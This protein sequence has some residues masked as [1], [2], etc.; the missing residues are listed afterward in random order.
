MNK[1]AVRN[2]VLLLII[3]LLISIIFSIYNISK[4]SNKQIYNED[5]IVSYDAYGNPYTSE[6]VSENIINGVN[7]YYPVIIFTSI[8]LVLI[9]IVFY[10]YLY[11]KKQW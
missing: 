7:N 1:K 10:S 8:A 5:A 3:P 9:F 6:E 4:N 11:R 2:I